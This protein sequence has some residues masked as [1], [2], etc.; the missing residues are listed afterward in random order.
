MVMGYVD[1]GKILL[2]DYICCVKVVVG[3]VGGIMQYIGVYY[4]DMLCGVIMFFD[5]LGYEVF[6]VMCVC[7]VKVIDIVVLVV[8]VDDGVMLQMKEVIV[9]VK[10]G[11]VLIVVVINK[12]DKLE[13]NLDCVKQELVVEGVVLEEYGG[14]LLF[15]LVLVKMGVGIDDL[16]ENVLLQVEVLELKVLVEVLVKGIVIEVKFDKGKGLVVMI[17]VQFGMLNCGDIVLVGMVY[18]C[19]C[20]M[21]D[22]NG[23]LMKEVGL[24]ILV[25][26]QGLLEVL[27]VGEEVIVL[28]D[29]CKVCE[30]VL[31]C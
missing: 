23:K 12:I 13:V 1:Y 30:I 3:E 8:V 31:F 22:E 25:E 24:L 28:L 16:F 14:D 15:V 20:V 27:G 18:G 21:F 2:F 7:G 26:I 17:L 10:V 19:V 29:E 11:G 5:M 4:V 9:Y 6:M